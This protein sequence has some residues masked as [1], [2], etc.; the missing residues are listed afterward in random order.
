[1]EVVRGEG[2][3]WRS[4]L[5]DVNVGAGDVIMVACVGGDGGFVGREEGG[6]GGN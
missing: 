6:Q 3:R 2:S 4:W 1:M 5:V